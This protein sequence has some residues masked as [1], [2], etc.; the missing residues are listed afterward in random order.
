[1]FG[2]LNNIWV[3]KNIKATKDSPMMKNRIPN[4]NALVAVS[5]LGVS[6]GGRDVFVSIIPHAV[7][8]L[9]SSNQNQH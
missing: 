5:P 7:A 4:W 2:S 1:M 8:H 9:L 6:A 3:T